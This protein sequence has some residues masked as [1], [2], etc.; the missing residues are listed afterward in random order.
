MSTVQRHKESVFFCFCW[1]PFVD[2][3]H[4]CF[5]DI[6]NFFNEVFTCS[7]YSLLFSNLLLKVL[8]CIVQEPLLWDII[9]GRIPQYFNCYIIFLEGLPTCVFCV[10]VF[11]VVNIMWCLFIDLLEIILEMVHNNKKLNL[12]SEVNK[13][14]KLYGFFFHVIPFKSIYKVLSPWGH[15][16]SIEN[17]QISKI[18]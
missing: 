17:H 10:C 15:I 12:K 8:N 2:W 14:S 4:S 3:N 5:I 9:L 11:L 6:C 16:N 7:R 18:S 1:I 13:Q